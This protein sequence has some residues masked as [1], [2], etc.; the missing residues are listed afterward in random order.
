MQRNERSQESYR[1]ISV[2]GLSGV[3][4]RCANNK[5]RQILVT[6][7]SRGLI[8]HRK[9]FGFRGCKLMAGGLKSTGKP[10]YLAVLSACLFFFKS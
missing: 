9:G 6:G 5:T 1:S 4:G 7:Y 8:C 3:G 2:L 10:F